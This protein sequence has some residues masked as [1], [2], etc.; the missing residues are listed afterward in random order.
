LQ[1]WS[2]SSTT[3]PLEGATEVVGVM[4]VLWVLPVVTAVGLVRE[5]GAVVITR[6]VGIAEVVGG[7]VVILGVVGVVDVGSVGVDVAEVAALLRSE[8]GIAVGP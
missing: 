2:H 4:G 6:E 7:G 8:D 5:L 1:S 3:G